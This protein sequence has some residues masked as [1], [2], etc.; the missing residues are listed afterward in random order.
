[1]AVKR[2]S[3]S[4]DESVAERAAS[5]AASHGVSLSAWLNAA[6]E[7]AIRIEDG[8]AAGREWEEEHGELSAEELAWA[9]KV[10]ADDRALLDEIVPEFGGR[11]AAINEGIATLADDHRR[12]RALEAFMEEW[13]A[14]SGP[15]DPDG[16]AAMSE[17]FFSQR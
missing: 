9:D 7:R 10:I 16:V 6:A 8:L 15:P 14:E 5:A 12:S 3:V 17:R 13:S 11:S 2:L 1:M 4:L